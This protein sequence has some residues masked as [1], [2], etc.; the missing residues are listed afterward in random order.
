MS[1]VRAADVKVG[2]VLHQ[3][4]WRGR[5]TKTGVLGGLVLLVDDDGDEHF[6][7]AD[8]HVV[9]TPKA[10]A[11]TPARRLAVDGLVALAEARRIATEIRSNPCGAMC[12]EVYD[13]DLEELLDLLAPPTDHPKDPA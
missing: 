13:A 3:G 1:K 2:D 9:V 8:R 12:L 5:I 10:T 11:E 7:D 4:R 6:H